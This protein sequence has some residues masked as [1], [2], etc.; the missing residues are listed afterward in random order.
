MRGVGG[1]RSRRARAI[2]SAERNFGTGQRSGVGGSHRMHGTWKMKSERVKQNGIPAP[3]AFF[4]PGQGALWK[5]GGLERDLDRENAKGKGKEREEGE[6]RK[7]RT[8]NERRSATSREEYNCQTVSPFL[9]IFFVCCLT[10][11]RV[12]YTY[13]VTLPWFNTTRWI[14]GFKTTLSSL[15]PTL[16]PTSSLSPSLFLISSRSFPDEF[17]GLI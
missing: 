17:P 1:G 16:T 12:S 14:P 10:N 7:E 9:F 3:V 2:S 11:P 13:Q 4:T 6:K 15:P 5:V 8:G